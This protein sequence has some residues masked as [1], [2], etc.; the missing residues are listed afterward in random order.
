MGC[1]IHAYS[2]AKLFRHDDPEKENGVWVSADKWTVSKYGA[3]YGEAEPESF[4]GF[5][6]GHDDEIFYKRNY[7]LFALLAG[8]RNYS[9]VIPLARPR[10]IP[11]D[12][13]TQ[14]GALASQYGDDGH[15]H[16]WL[17][18]NDI[19]SALSDM[20]ITG[21]NELVFSDLEAI[22]SGLEQRRVSFGCLSRHVRIVFWFDN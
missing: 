1:D 9:G 18:L 12:V 19:E 8:V 20:L 15:N 7:S 21:R 6:V 3:L 22:R 4:S 2:E 5:E 11:Q 10:G 16:S 13:S 17:G 14:V